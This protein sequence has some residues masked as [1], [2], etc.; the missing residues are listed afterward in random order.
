MSWDKAKSIAHL[1]ANAK[2]PYGVGMCATYVRQALEAGGLDVPQT[3][4]GSAKDYGPRL[5]AVG[6]KLVPAPYIA[7]EAGD[8][9]VIDGFMKE[10][11]E[12]IKKNHPDGHLAL[13]DGSDWISDFKQEGSTPYPGSDYINAAPRFLIYRY[14]SH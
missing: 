14:Q 5:I 7:Y 3:G 13:Y 12:G 8:V 6:F 11:A 2:P 10:A 1:R 9:A 4:S